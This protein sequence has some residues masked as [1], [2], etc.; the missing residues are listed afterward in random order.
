MAGSSPAP[1]LQRGSTA[2]Q[3]GRLGLRLHREPEALEL[4]AGEG[5]QAA[6]SLR[7][8]V[9][10]ARVLLHLSP[11]QGTSLLG[12]AFSGIR[13]VFLPKASTVRWD[14]SCLLSGA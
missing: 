1:S 12:R 14:H 2:T 10:K 11:H 9:R 3:R 6:A 7:P 13:D 8:R 4:H 5:P